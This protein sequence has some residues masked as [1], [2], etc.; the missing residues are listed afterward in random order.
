MSKNTVSNFN[1]RM[2]V[3]C[4]LFTALII[5]GGYIS[6]PIPVGPVPIVLADFFVMITGLFLGLK[7]GLISTALYLA[8][9]ALGMPVFAGGGAGLAVLVGPTGGFLF[10]YLLVVTSIGFITG[11]RKPSIVTNLIALVVGNILLYAIGVPWLKFQMNINWAAALAAGLI[12][13]IIGIVIKI[14][15]ASALGRVLLP[16]FKQTLVSA[17]VQQA[18]IG[19][20]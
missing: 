8:L 7:Y 9:G 15:V 10:G 5:I 1:L 6:I 18:E 13:F 2:T 11:K 12:P 3:Y 14:T 4:A 16:R 19:E 17:S 20:E